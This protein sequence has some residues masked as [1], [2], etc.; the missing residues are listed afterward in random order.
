MFVGNFFCFVWILFLSRTCFKDIGLIWFLK[1]SLASSKT[2]II[3]LLCSNAGFS[4]KQF[5]SVH[6]GAKPHDY[7]IR[8][9]NCG[10]VNF[11]PYYLHQYT[12]C[13]CELCR[14]SDRGTSSVRL[15]SCTSTY[16]RVPSM[17]HTRTLWIWA[18]RFSAVLLQSLTGTDVPAMCSK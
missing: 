9:Q 7:G 5:L 18:L 2:K 17:R 15:D 16:Q 14:R 8:L 4:Y 1:S 6:F 12:L 13:M 10:A 11:V 3:Q